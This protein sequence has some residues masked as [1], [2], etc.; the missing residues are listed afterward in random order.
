LAYCRL[1]SNNF[2]NLPNLFYEALKIRKRLN[3]YTVI[4]GSYIHLSEYYQKKGNGKFAI[5][6][7]KLSLNFAKKSKI[8]GNIILALKQASLVDDKNAKKYSED[9]IRISDSIQVAERNS[10]DRFDRLQLETD[11]IKK[12]NNDLEEKK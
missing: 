11:E 8:P 3:N 1:Q 9:Y 10:K 5:E 7:S 12:E 6:N 2:T 4:I